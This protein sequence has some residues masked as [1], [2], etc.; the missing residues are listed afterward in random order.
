VSNGLA[1]GGS[2][3]PSLIEGAKMAAM[4]LRAASPVLVGRRSELAALEAALD[5]AVA[6]GSAVALVGGEAGIGKSRL[7]EEFAA[8]AK[9]RGWRICVG[10]CLQLGEAAWPL[11]PLSE[12]VTTLVDVLDDKS[13][14]AVLGDARGVLAHLV[15]VLGGEAAGDTL[16][17]SEQRL[18]DADQITQTLRHLSRPRHV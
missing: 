5:A 12:I 16:V 2:S 10:R 13:L 4:G 8:L 3:G 17:S 1:V 18:A 11:A 7:V 15:P 6:E 14:E 9:R